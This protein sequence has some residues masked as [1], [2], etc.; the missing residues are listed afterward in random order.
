MA[1]SRYRPL[2]SMLL[3]AMYRMFGIWAFPSQALNL[4][5]HLLSVCLLYQLVRRLGQDRAIAFLAAAMTLIS[6]YTVSPAIWVSDRPTLLVGLFTLLVLNIVCCGPARRIRPLQLFVLS[7]LAL[8]AKESGLILP[9]FVLI[10]GLVGP[11][12]RPELVL[13]TALL[14]IL[15]MVL[16]HNLFP[17]DIIGPHESGYMLGL[18]WYEDWT[19]FSSPYRLAL[20]AENSLK[21]FIG[22]FLPV[23]NRNGGFYPLKELLLFS[24]TW[25]TTVWLAVAYVKPRKGLSTPQQYALLL[26]GLN[27][28]MHFGLFRH[29][30]MYISQLA[31]AL[32][33]ASSPWLKSCA[34]KGVVSENKGKRFRV[35]AAILLLSS[36]LWIGREVDMQWTRRARRLAVL[37]RGHPIVDQVLDRYGNDACR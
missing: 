19:G 22:V 28:L 15:Y 16:R 17:P 21:S 27:A 33:I 31:F 11:R 7:C 26:I 29:R 30:N 32:L 13:S 24:P 5:L 14:I 18:W 36:A 6:I 25:L 35:I 23:F 20:A 1:N 8:M 2:H 34:D 4:G 9:L 10:I 37:Q 3:W 12:R